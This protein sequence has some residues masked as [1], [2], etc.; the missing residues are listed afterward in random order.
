MKVKIDIELWDETSAEKLESVGV[1]DK[2]VV[3]MYKNA[4]KEI[5]EEICVEGMEYS[6]NVEVEDNTKK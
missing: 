4:F 1:T 3:I 5:L 6:L 2:L